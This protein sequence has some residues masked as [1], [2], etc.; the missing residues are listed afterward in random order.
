[1]RILYG[2]ASEGMGHA[3]RSKVAL[4][5]LARSHELMVVCGGRPF[6]VLSGQFENVHEIVGTG[7]AYGGNALT[8]WRTIGV[9]VKRAPKA[10]PRNA[11]VLWGVVKDFKP[12]LVITDFESLTSFYA[13]VSKTRLVSI[14][15]MQIADKCEIEGPHSQSLYR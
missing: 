1:M 6:E 15:N 12:D 7:L 10:I 3:I 4:D 13:D 9:N 5:W 2:L 14:D 11:A 8:F